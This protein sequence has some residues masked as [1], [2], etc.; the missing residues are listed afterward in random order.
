MET[1]LELSRKYF[2]MKST[3]N[4][5]KDLGFKKATSS[6]NEDYP[7]LVLEAEN[8]T[9]ELDPWLDFRIFNKGNKVGIKIDCLQLADVLNWIDF[10]N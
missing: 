2:S 1:A 8:F 4:A 6:E 3:E 10:I 7:A 9:L 5:L